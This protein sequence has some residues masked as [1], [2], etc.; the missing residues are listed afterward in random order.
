MVVSWYCLD[1]VVLE[2]M[3][4][5]SRRSEVAYIDGSLSTPGY[6]LTLLRE[7]SQCPRA[8][9]ETTK[10]KQVRKMNMTHFL[11]QLKK[12]GWKL[13]PHVSNL[14][15]GE[16]ILYILQ[17]TTPFSLCVYQVWDSILWNFGCLVTYLCGVV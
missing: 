14:R 6:L 17:E 4:Q 10:L 11:D 2:G 1:R 8:L 3:S 5:V 13:D 9:T 12:K 15:S 16:L 7:L